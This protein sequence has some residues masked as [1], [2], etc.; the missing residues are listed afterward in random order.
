MRKEVLD[1]M[2]LCYASNLNCV[3]CCNFLANVD[4][5]KL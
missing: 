4:A 1:M 3:E 2:E 5:H